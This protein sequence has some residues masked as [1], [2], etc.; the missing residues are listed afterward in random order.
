MQYARKNITPRQVVQNIRG[1]VI[2]LKGEHP[3]VNRVGNVNKFIQRE[4]HSNEIDLSIWK[5][6]TI[7]VKLLKLL[8]KYFE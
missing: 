7:N 8:K 1:S 5:I 2:Y 3:Y 4:M 6:R